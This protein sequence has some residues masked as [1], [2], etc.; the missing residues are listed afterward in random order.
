M[1]VIGVWSNIETNVGLWCCC[2]P[3]LQPLIQGAARRL[4]IS[5]SAAGSSPKHS[6]PHGASG[7]S[8][9]GQGSNHIRTI[10]QRSLRAAPRDPN[11]ID[12]D[13]DDNSS[14]RRIVAVGDKEAVEL[15]DLERGPSVKEQQQQQQ[16]QHGPGQISRTTEV[17]ITSHSE[18]AYAV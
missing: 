12:T 6:S 14:E 15:R 18:G 2:F 13:S 5:S 11:A 7:A 8:G 3:A 16:Q 9:G 17:T 10:G 4:G 1:G